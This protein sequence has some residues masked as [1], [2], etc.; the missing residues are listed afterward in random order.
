VTQCQGAPFTAAGA[1]AKVAL[2]RSMRAQATNAK[3]SLVFFNARHD[4]TH[5]STASV[6]LAAVPNP[7]SLALACVCVPIV[8][9]VCKWLLCTETCGSRTE[10]IYGPGSEVTAPVICGTGTT[11]G[12]SPI[13]SCTCDADLST[14]PYYSYS[15]SGYFEASC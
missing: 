13:Q 10:Y 14:T 4:M 3:A 11:C 15:S 1:A 5:C 6:V 8:S 12:G 9:A 7:L 2:F